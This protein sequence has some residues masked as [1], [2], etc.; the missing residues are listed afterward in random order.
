VPAVSES[1]YLAFK[2]VEVHLDNTIYK[3]QFVPYFQTAP[4]PI[5]N[6]VRAPKMDVQ[7]TNDV[8]YGH[9]LLFVKRSNTLTSVIFQI[10]V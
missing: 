4:A 10:F 7:N 5:Y 2:N 8:G 6:M 9:S 1:A 3:R